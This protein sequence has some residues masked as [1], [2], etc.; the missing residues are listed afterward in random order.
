MISGST[1]RKWNWLD[2]SGEGGNTGS[3]ILI[4]KGSEG[5]ETR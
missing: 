5:A 4:G 3:D 2:H 1:R